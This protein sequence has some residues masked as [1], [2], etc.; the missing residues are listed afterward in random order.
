MLRKSSHLFDYYNGDNIRNGSIGDVSIE[1]YPVSSEK[2]QRFQGRNDT[3]NKNDTVWSKAY[4]A[5]RACLL[6][7]RSL[8]S[9]STEMDR[10]PHLKDEDHVKKTTFTIGYNK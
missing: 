10:P 6:T 7:V 8:A 9:Y 2:S 3:P 5:R 1:T 4:N